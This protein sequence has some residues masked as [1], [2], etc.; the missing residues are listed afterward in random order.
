[1]VLVMMVSMAMVRMMLLT[2]IMVV[3]KILPTEIDNIVS[4]NG[5]SGGEDITVRDNIADGDGAGDTPLMMVT[6]RH[7]VM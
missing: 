2:V 7:W 6:I 4:G 5:G 3:V 1:M